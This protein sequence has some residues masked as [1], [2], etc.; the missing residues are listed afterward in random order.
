MVFQTRTEKAYNLRFHLSNYFFLQLLYCKKQNKNKDYSFHLWRNIPLQKKNIFMKRFEK[1][2]LLW[3][4][5]LSSVSI[6]KSWSKR[7]KGLWW[8]VL[9][10]EIPCADEFCSI[11]PTH[12]FL[13]EKKRTG[14]QLY[15][16]TEDYSGI[17]F[18]VWQPPKHQLQ[19]IS[20]MHLVD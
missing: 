17:S 19:V 3:T 2:S 4:P 1:A 10:K 13:T 14:W 5:Y 8:M 15:S 18:F 11:N 20:S 12:H 6:A 16:F 7:W 9:L